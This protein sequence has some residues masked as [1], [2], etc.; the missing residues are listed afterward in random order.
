MCAPVVVLL[1]GSCRVVGVLANLLAAPL[2]A[3]G[4]GRP[5]SRRP[6][7]LRCGRAGARLVAGRGGADASG[8]ARVGPRFAD[9]ARAAR[10][11]GPTGARGRPARR[12][13]R[14]GAAHRPRW[15]A[16]R[17][18]AHPVLAAG[19]PRSWS[20]G[21][22][23]DLGRHLAAGGW[24][25]V[26]C[27]VGQGDA[28]VLRGGAGPRGA[29]RRR[30]RPGPGRPLPEPARRRG[31]STPWCSP[32][33]TPT[34]STGCPGPSTAARSRE[35]L[36]DARSATRPPVATRCD[37]VGARPRHTGRGDCT[38]ATSSPSA[39]VTADGLVAGAAHRR[40]VGAQQ[41]QRRAGRPRPGPSTRCCSAT[42]SARPPTPC[43]W[44]CGA[45]LRWPR[46]SGSFDVVKVAHHGSANL[47]E[48]LMEAVAAPVARHQRRRGQRLR[49]PRAASAWRC[50]RRN[51]Y[52]RLPHR[53]ARR[54]RR[55][56][57]QDGG[58]TWRGG[59]ARADARRL[60][61]RCWRGPGAWPWPP[62]RGRRWWPGPRAPAGGRR[63]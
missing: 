34:T 52:R 30:A 25:F 5:G 22:A 2:V 49:P 39:G 28:L 45:T 63:W 32:T 24:R 15:V 61:V 1:Q 48:G 62:R 58:V 33:S 60:G 44:R 13:D 11:P 51:G 46:R 57:G 36:V 8:I 47:D 56:R 43:C 20:P 9:G 27:D 53:P 35:L 59:D 54:R 14:R 18:R 31:R 41:R 12:A 50:L 17:A 23:P 29:R 3:A 26:A 21:A 10:C 42:S 55:R 38:P 37:G 6:W 4:D 16:H 40:G 19:L 7:W